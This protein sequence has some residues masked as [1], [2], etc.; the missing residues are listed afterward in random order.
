[1]DAYVTNNLTCVGSLILGAN[2]TATD[3]VTYAGVKFTFVSSI[4]TTAGNVLIGASASATADN[5]VAAI[6]GAA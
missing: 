1:M 4:G 5:L 6:N 2:P 3:T